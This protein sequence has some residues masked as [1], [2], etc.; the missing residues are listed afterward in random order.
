[1]FVAQRIRIKKLC[2]F[3]ELSLYDNMVF[4][5]EY[6]LAQEVSLMDQR[7][8]ENEREII[9]RFQTEQDNIIKVYVNKDLQAV[10]GF[11]LTDSEDL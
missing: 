4:L 7:V 8:R 1:M 3:A 5:S 2:I 9:F 11:L 6:N 10:V